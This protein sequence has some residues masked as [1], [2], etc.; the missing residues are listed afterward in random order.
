MNVQPPPRLKLVLVGD[1]GVGKTTLAKMWAGGSF[2][3][4]YVATVGVDVH[5]VVVHTNLGSVVLD[6]WDCAGQEKFA[7]LRDRYFISGQAGLA[8]GDAGSQQS[9]QRARSEWV[10]SMRRVMGEVPIVTVTAKCK[11]GF[12]TPA[13]DQNGDNDNAGPNRSGVPNFEV[14]AEANWNIWEPILWILRR[15]TGSGTL[16]IVSPTSPS[17]VAADR[18][19]NAPTGDVLGAASV[20]NSG[21][22]TPFNVVVV[23][24]V[25]VG[26]SAYIK[27]VADVDCHL[28]S[29]TESGCAAV[30]Q[31]N[32]IDPAAGATTIT[33]RLWEGLHNVPQT[34]T[35]HGAMIMFDVTNRD[36]YRKLPSHYNE[37]AQL[38]DW[39]RPSACLV[40]NKCDT[41]DIKVTPKMVVF[42]RKKNLMLYCT[43]AELQANVLKPIEYLVRKAANAPQLRLE[44]T[45]SIGQ[46]VHAPPNE[47]TPRRCGSDSTKTGL[48]CR[49]FAPCRWHE[50]DGSK[51]ATTTAPDS[52]QRV[53]AEAEAHRRLAGYELQCA[54][55]FQPLPEDDED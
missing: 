26:K 48:P 9:Q 17:L 4:R 44:P 6:I 35:I 22:P 47:G 8:F 3:T 41:D 32:V 10:P 11:S 40:A 21:V 20:T 42:H 46:S 33:L 23:G 18:P 24:E 28:A 50:D 29:S 2:E 51:R 43:S 5:H 37:L 14:D 15:L 27:A 38:W 36:T 30:T 13:M 34:A 54:C 53:G 16:M 25:G 7:G 31:L 55:N 1:G 39:V 45:A 19:A 12:G 52:D 49:N